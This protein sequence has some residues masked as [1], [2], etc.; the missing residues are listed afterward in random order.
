MPHLLYL[1]IW[2]KS[3]GDCQPHSPSAQQGHG[4]RGEGWLG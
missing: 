3:M 1:V 2:V 4:P